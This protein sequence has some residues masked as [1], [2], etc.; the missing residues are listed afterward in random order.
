[1]LLRVVTWNG[2]TVVAN[3]GPGWMVS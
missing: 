1:L 3:F 2:P